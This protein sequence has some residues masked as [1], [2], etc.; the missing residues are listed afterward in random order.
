MFKRTLLRGFF[1]LEVCVFIGVYMFGPSGLQRMIS[2]K[3]ENDKLNQELSSLKKEVD[4]WEQK[5]TLW[6]SDDFYKEKVAREKL[7]MARSSDEV[8]YLQ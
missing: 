3:G 6:K 1:V 8:F 7:Q 2:L 4:L 5:I